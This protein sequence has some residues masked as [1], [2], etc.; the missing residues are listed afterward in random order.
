MR[1]FL[2]LLLAVALLGLPLPAPAGAA[3]PAL[4]PWYGFDAE[5]AG[6]PRIGEPFEVLATLTSRL[7]VLEEISVTLMTPAGW[8]VSSPT[9]TLGRLASGTSRLFRFAVTPT[10]PLPNGS[11]GCKL[12]VR[13]P[14]TALIEQ[15]GRL[16]SQEASKIADVIK[17]RPDV[18]ESF[19]DMAFALFPQEGFYPLASDMWLTY[20]DRLRPEGFERGPVLYRD[21]MI[22]PFQAQT[23]VEMHDKLQALLK[24]D[25]KLREELER[26]G[27]D[28]RKKK[29]DQLLGLYVLATEAFLKGDHQGA[30]ALLHRFAVESEN[31]DGLPVELLVAAENLRGLA[32]WALGDRKTAEQALQKAFYRNR[33]LPVQRYILRNIGMLMASRGDRATARE[34]LRLA[35]EMKPAYVLVADEYR[36][37]KER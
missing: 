30:E 9:I 34:M 24:S 29:F 8:I 23:D 5:L 16:F 21:G 13:M 22:T 14:K 26:K 17:Q 27:I 18:H 31:V 20:D 35:S 12:R 10:G 32:A 19:T 15:A 7:G 4:P 28:L 11:I 36:R 33:K 37:L 25:P 2:R 1:H 6:P 3:T